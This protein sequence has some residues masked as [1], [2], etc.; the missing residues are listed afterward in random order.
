[1]RVWHNFNFFFIVVEILKKKKERGAIKRTKYLLFLTKI[2]FSREQFTVSCRVHSYKARIFSPNEKISKHTDGDN[3]LLLS[4]FFS[5]FDIPPYFI[6]GNNSS[7]ALCL[8]KKHV[9]SF[10]K[11][12]VNE[13][14]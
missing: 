7:S 10:G 4:F 5:Y 6:S 11:A 3:I 2:Q 1:M 8:L 9:F 12:Y 13:E 14:L